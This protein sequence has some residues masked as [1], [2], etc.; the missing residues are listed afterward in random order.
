MRYYEDIETGD[1]HEYGPYEMTE[2]EMLEFARQYDPQ[3]FHADPGAAADTRYEG[4]IASGW[5]T[6]A[7]CMR[8]IAEGLL[9]GAA[10]YGSPGIEELSWPAPVRPG[11]DLSVTVE[12]TGTRRSESNPDVGLVNADWEATVNG[13][14]RTVMTLSTLWFFE[15]RAAADA[16]DD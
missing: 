6:G 14:E 15:R 13:G 16:A 12:I 1:V 10:T 9:D 5:H 2:A 8:L 7:V 11:D 4:I 3:P